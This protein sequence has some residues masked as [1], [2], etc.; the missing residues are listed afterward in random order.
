MRGIE[1]DKI[2]KM[3]ILYDGV[4]FQ[5]GMQ[6]GGVH[7]YAQNL[8]SGIAVMPDTEV[9]L[10]CPFRKW[11]ETQKPRIRCVK[12][13][14]L[15]ENHRFCEYA[16]R[17]NYV[18]ERLEG[19]LL[20]LRT[21]APDIFH[22]TYY[23]MPCRFGIIVVTLYDMLMERFPDFFQGSYCDNVRRQKRKCL[24]SAAHVICISQNTRR[25]VTEMF[26]IP[27]ERTSVIYLGADIVTE[28]QNTRLPEKPYFLYV[29]AR[30]PHKNFTGL[31]QAFGS[32]KH[33]KDITLFVVSNL[34]EW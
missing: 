33:K 13:Y 5:E 28:P 4:A 30:W 2:I 21:P 14:R 7:R 12:E 23:R 16:K 29:G 31:L 17:A 9:S 26:G 22:L 34:A 18:I 32:C 15:R 24:E 11:T 19:V 8:I 27:P 3:H 20:P 6:G 10:Y 1:E 25:D